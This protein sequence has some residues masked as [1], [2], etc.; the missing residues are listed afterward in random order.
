MKSNAY[1]MKVIHTSNS[2]P[3]FT[4]RLYGRKK[5]TYEYSNNGDHHQ[6]FDERE[7]KHAAT[8]RNPHPTD[9]VTIPHD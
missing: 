8:C 6:Q 7:P 4:S 9:Y 1:L 3:A 5:Q 2:S